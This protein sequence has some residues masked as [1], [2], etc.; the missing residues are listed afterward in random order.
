MKIL[1]ICGS[2]EN[3]R[4]GVGDYT[5]RLS[6]ELIRQGHQVQVIALNDKYIGSDLNE[7]QKDES[8]GINCLR[9]S[10]KLS[11]KERMA[12]AKRFV[13][14]FDPEWLSLQFVPFSFQEKGLPLGFA[15][16]LKKL[17]YGRNWH[18][19][20][21]ELWLGID[22]ESSYK[23][24][25]WGY[26]Q[27][28]L[29]ITIIKAIK[30]K[31]ITTHTNTYQA[32]LSDLGI[33]ISILPLFSNIPRISVLPVKNASLLTCV[34]FG[35]IHG[36]AP[37]HSF[38]KDL[39]IYSMSIDRKLNFI[40][41]GRNGNEAKEW[42]D[43]LDELKIEYQNIGECIPEEISEYISKSDL[44][45]STTPYYLAEKSGTVAAFL[46]HQL[47][48][49]CVARDWTPTFKKKLVNNKNIIHYKI[50]KTDF[51]NLNTWF[52]TSI[53]V[54]LNAITSQFVGLLS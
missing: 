9:L 49:I 23:M 21:H 48:V 18:V 8:V 19:M 2:L 1:F 52:S 53:N 29:V 10:S 22:R 27:K 3:G 16:R 20:F 4:D 39:L 17:G 11:W 12:V 44:G 32:V 38:M 46:D 24:K 41:V 35:G 51:S 34:L 5:R 15:I 54:D 36:G 45:I 26:V 50:G 28:Q 40:F 30:P 6:G 25:V 43:V 47:P 14:D 7:T 37:V 31:Y 42:I 13:E 33:Q